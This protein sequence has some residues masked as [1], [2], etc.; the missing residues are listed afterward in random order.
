MKYASVALLAFA[1][2]EPST[3]LAQ[4]QEWSCPPVEKVGLSANSPGWITYDTLMIPYQAPVLHLE[5]MENSIHGPG[6]A[7]KYRVENSGLLTIWKLGKCENGKGTWTSQGPKSTCESRNPSD[8]SLV[9]SP[10]SAPA[11]PGG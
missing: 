9:C 3:S 10:V 11:K 6:A 7:C 2:F 1:L 5:S 4:P 8:C